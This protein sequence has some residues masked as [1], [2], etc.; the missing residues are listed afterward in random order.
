M[1]DLQIQQRIYESIKI[2][3]WL[4]NGYGVNYVLKACGPSKHITSEWIVKHYNVEMD[5]FKPHLKH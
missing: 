2:I 1:T 5:Y 3:E 4:V